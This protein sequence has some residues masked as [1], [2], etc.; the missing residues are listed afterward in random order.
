V[1]VRSITGQAVFAFWPLDR[2]G[3]VGQPEPGARGYRA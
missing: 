3:D 1:P 2:L